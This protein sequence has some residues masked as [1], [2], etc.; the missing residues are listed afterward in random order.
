MTSSA[1]LPVVT[2]ASGW[3]VCGVDGCT[4]TCSSVGRLEQH[5][6]DAHGIIFMC[7]TCGVEPHW[8]KET[9]CLGC[10]RRRLEE[11][12]R[13]RARCERQWDSICDGRGLMCDWRLATFPRDDSAG[14]AAYDAVQPWLWL[15]T[16][17]FQRSDGTWVKI[18]YPH[19]SLPVQPDPEIAD[20]NH[21]VHEWSGL[22]YYEL[23]LYIWGGV[24]SGKTGLAWSLLR[25]YT[26]TSD[27]YDPGPTFA[28]VV[29]LLDQAKAAMRE[30]DGGTPIRKLYDASLLVLDDLG[31]E[32]PTDWARDAIAAL[33][34]HRH[35][36]GLPTVVTSNYAP[37][38]LARRLGHDDL[39]IGKRI[40]SRLTENCFK[41]KLDRADLRALRRSA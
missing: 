5:R 13:A 26:L 25:A 3:Y 2:D 16:N 9:E 23:G 38:A 1:G 41:V 20:E 35:T 36:R 34:Q 27:G 11:E 31:A 15:H 18:V 24:G 6:E 21:P 7:H 32:R 33:V 39:M 37:S 19:P 17:H 10:L 22:D 4:R 30:G 28:N 12:R 29:E 14:A 8:R 40:V